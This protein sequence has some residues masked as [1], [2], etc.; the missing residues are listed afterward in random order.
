M[1]TLCQQIME[2]KTKILIGIGIS[3]IAAVLISGC[4]EEKL[5]NNTIQNETKITGEPPS[6]SFNISKCHAKQDLDEKQYMVLSREW[7]DDKTI[8]IVIATRANCCT[9]K[10][11]DFELNDSKINLYVIESGVQCNCLCIFNAIYV[12]SN[13]KKRDYETDF[14]LITIEQSQITKEQAI[15]IANATE[16]VQEF[17]KLYPDAKIITRSFGPYCDP[18]PC[19]WTDFRIIYYRDKQTRDKQTV[20]RIDVDGTTGEILAKY[21]KLEYLKNLRYCESDEDCNCAHIEGFE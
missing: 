16:E 13:L 3:L 1:P 14:I 17:L 11:G 12:I 7:V 9:D 2:Q 8:K 4:V 20:A 6:L 15:S 21:P 19:E 5:Q 18:L 10:E